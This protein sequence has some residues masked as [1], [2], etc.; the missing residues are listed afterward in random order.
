MM[1]PGKFIGGQK[2]D[3]TGF[4][5]DFSDWI[6]LE[7]IVVNGLLEIK[8]NS[9]VVYKDTLSV[10]PGKLVGVRYKFHGTGAVRSLEIQSAGQLAFESSF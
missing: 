7:V 3:L 10:D 8:V 1:L 6:E 5:V 4:G 2:N 9:Q